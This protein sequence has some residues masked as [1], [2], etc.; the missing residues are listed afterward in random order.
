MIRI[1]F[2]PQHT[3]DLSFAEPRRRFSQCREYRLQIECRTAYDLEHVGGGGLLRER[4]AQF[5]KQACVLDGD[6]GLVGKGLDQFDL[7]LGER[8][9]HRLCDEE[10][11][12]DFS[13]PQK[14]S[15]EAG[16]VATNLLRALPPVFR[17]SQHV[18]NMHHGRL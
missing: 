14:R 2:G 6:D 12:D 1:A 18:G 3:G 11:A 8:V 15:A 17:V 9:R 10:D 5:V 16:A 4:F 13:L 7:F